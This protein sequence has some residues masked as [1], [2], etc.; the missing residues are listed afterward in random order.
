MLSHTAAFAC[1]L[2][3]FPA[4]SRP[5]YSKSKLVSSYCSYCL[6]AFPSHSPGTDPTNLHI[7]VNMTHLPVT[8]RHDMPIHS[9]HTRTPEIQIRGKAVPRCH[10]ATRQHLS[11][12]VG[13]VQE[14]PPSS[15]AP[16]PLQCWPLY[17]TSNLFCRQAPWAIVIIT[18]NTI[19]YHEIIPLYAVIYTFV[20]ASCMLQQAPSFVTQLHQN[21]QLQPGL[22]TSAAFL[23]SPL[24]HKMSL[25]E[26]VIISVPGE[27]SPVPDSRVVFSALSPATDVTPAPDR[28]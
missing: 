19:S 22:A 3:F 10:L 23:A 7:L 14:L 6:P 25:P 11:A 13:I 2:T 15:P 18:I 28:D 26:P 8:T 21:T 24:N 12:L 20:Q 1:T 16:I 5:F 9:L 27:T 4:L 17:Y